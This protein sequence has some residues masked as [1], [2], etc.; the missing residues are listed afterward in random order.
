MNINYMVIPSLL[1]ELPATENEQAETIKVQD[2]FQAVELALINS[3]NLN[4]DDVCIRSRR[5]DVKQF[6]QAIHEILRR[7][8]KLSLG[9]IGDRTGHYDHATVLNS[10]RNVEQCEFIF[11]KTGTKYPLLEIFIELETRFLILW[12]PEKKKPRLHL[13]HP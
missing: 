11:H 6:R 10:K 5:R 1:E 12:Q 9:V 13:I 4:F 8:S 2:P 7:H 3:Y